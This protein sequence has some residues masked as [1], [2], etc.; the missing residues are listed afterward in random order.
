M[1]KETC[2]VENAESKYMLT[3]QRAEVFVNQNNKNIC[4]N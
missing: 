2:V 3:G 1:K 4:F